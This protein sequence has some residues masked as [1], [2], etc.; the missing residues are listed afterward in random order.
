MFSIANLIRKAMTNYPLFVAWCREKKEIWVPV[1]L[2]WAN[3]FLD[4]LEYIF[5]FRTIFGFFYK[6]VVSVV[7]WYTRPR[8][9]LYVIIM[10]IQLVSIF[11][12]FVLLF[13]FWFCQWRW[14]QEIHQLDATIAEHPILALTSDYT[15]KH[16]NMLDY[17]Y[18][19]QRFAESSFHYDRS[20]PDH[21]T[22]FW[23][24]I[25]TR[26]KQFFEWRPSWVS[27]KDLLNEYR[28]M[29]DYHLQIPKPDWKAYFFPVFCTW[30]S[31]LGYYDYLPELLK[32][33]VVDGR[34]PVCH[35][36]DLFSDA[37]LLA[38]EEWNMAHHI[39]ML[40]W[41]IL[42][43]FPDEWYL[44]HES[45]GYYTDFMFEVFNDLKNF[46]EDEFLAPYRDYKYD[47]KQYR[48]MIKPPL[49]DW[50]PGRL[51]IRD[52]LFDI[53][54]VFCFRYIAPQ[55]AARTLCRL[56][57]PITAYNRIGYYGVTFITYVYGVPFLLVSYF[58][59][60][61][62]LYFYIP[63][64]AAIFTNIATSV[65]N[66]FSYF[67]EN[68][69]FMEELFVVFYLLLDEDSDL[70]P[71]EI[72]ISH[73]LCFLQDSWML[74]SIFPF[75]NVLVVLPLIFAFGIFRII[76]KPFR[77]FYHLM[78]DHRTGD[79]RT[80]VEVSDIIADQ[81]IVF[82]EAYGFLAFRYY[83]YLKS[84]LIRA[85]YNLP[86]LVFLP[87]KYRR[88]AITATYKWKNHTGILRGEWMFREYE[89]HKN[90]MRYI[91]EEGEEAYEKL[92]DERFWMDQ[93][94]YE[95]DYVEQQCIS[96]DNI[97]YPRVF[98]VF[99]LAGHVIL[100]CFVIMGFISITYKKLLVARLLSDAV[101]ANGLTPFTLGTAAHPKDRKGCNPG[102]DDERDEEWEPYTEFLDAFFAAHIPGTYIDHY[103]EVV[104]VV[105]RWFFLHSI[106]FVTCFIFAL[107]FFRSFRDILVPYIG[108]VL[109]GFLTYL[110]VMGWSAYAFSGGFPEVDLLGLRGP[111]NL[112][113]LGEE[114]LFDNYLTGLF[115]IDHDLARMEQY[116]D[117][118][119]KFRIEW[120]RYGRFPKYHIN[121]YW[122]VYMFIYD[123]IKDLNPWGHFVESYRDPELKAFLAKYEP[124]FK[125]WREYFWG[126]EENYDG[127]DDED[128][129]KKMD[130][131][132]K[133]KGKKSDVDTKK[134]SKK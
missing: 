94:K 84:F 20:F 21:P 66:F 130:D 38:M 2:L 47:M 76:I 107:Y 93:E 30:V 49:P 103:A 9:L 16:A 24:E 97:P 132:D 121:R 125:E 111:L 92:L 18:I 22:S 118:S 7:T 106:F 25:V 95:R 80:F 85:P 56:I 133:V 75:L 119:A 109:L 29:R 55:A 110:F 113:M 60:L 65:N 79:L 23:K 34:Y 4:L 57:D 134:V 14:W 46:L 42:T 124:K 19:V 45:D 11:I 128:A 64:K 117:T 15:V 26:N 5:F 61:Y 13:Y 99:L 116:F 58:S 59:V 1:I 88:P 6:K 120:R 101:F 91:R 10:R 35:F 28:R 108:E 3:K 74:F 81:R 12:L 78:F 73:A 27:L 67:Q 8:L 52:C 70:I 48:K 131:K 44:R 98:V 127:L 87:R 77:L 126:E 122:G 89:K 17:L 71:Y 69:E 129:E 83:A 31:D 33:Y 43:S 115:T 100:S 40:P 51:V 50:G 37:W 39:K 102:W 72:T 96:V 53:Y 90:D 86:P 114:W 104:F 36:I 63:L 82:R 41:Y 68:I 32:D 112:L 123:G 54:E 62:T 105:Y